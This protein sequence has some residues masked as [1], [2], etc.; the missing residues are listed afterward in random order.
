VDFSFSN[1]PALIFMKLGV[2]DHV[3][4]SSIYKGEA[5]G[6]WIWGQPGQQNQKS[7]MTILSSYKMKHS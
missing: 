3:C 1:M 7:L 2:V 4:N 5:E 6:S